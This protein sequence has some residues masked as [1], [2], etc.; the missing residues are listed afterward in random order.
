MIKR[1]KPKTKINKCI[2]PTQKQSIMINKKKHNKK[3]VKYDK[4]KKQLS[5]INKTVEYTKKTKHI[6]ISNKKQLS[7]TKNSRV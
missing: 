2:I 4:K 5:M 3:T 1:Q 7:I 6:I